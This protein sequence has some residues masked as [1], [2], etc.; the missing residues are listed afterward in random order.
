MSQLMMF[1]FVFGEVIIGLVAIFVRDYKIFQAVL[2]FP[3]FILLGAYAVL[4]ESPRWLI[5]KHR[6][7]E[8]Q[9]VIINAAKFNHVSK[10][11]T[12]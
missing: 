10:Y 7:L 11:Y 4:P 1:G 6:Y 5:A 9:D 2:S 8:A 3:C 12:D